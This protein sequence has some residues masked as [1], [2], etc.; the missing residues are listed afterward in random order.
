MFIDLTMILIIAATIVTGLLAGASLDKAIVQLPARH[1]MEITGFAAFSR[2]NDLGNGLVF[3]PVLG[4]SAALLTILAAISAMI[5]RRPLALTWPL[6]VA[7]LLA[8]L[9][10]ITTARAAPKMLSLRQ[11]PIDEATLVRTLDDF[12]AW[13]NLRAV[14]QFLNFLILVWAI[15]TYINVL[16]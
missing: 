16:L 8:V 13:H 1:H 10:S 9:H 3:Y 7:V 5:Q 4:V 11:L 6:Y 12:A 15:I 2:A 14:L